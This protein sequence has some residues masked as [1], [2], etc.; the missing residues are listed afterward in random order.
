MVFV[1]RN[2]VEQKSYR[3]LSRLSVIINFFSVPSIILSLLGFVLSLLL[4]KTAPLKRGGYSQDADKEGMLTFSLAPCGEVH[5]KFQ[6]VLTE[7]MIGL[8]LSKSLCP[9]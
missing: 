9:L 8:Q 7:N 1:K 6:M 4:L 2:A 3:P 5:M